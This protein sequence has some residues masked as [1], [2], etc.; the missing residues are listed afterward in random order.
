[1]TG[2]YLKTHDFLKPLA[3]KAEEAEPTLR[4]GPTDRAP[5]VAH[6]LPGGIGTYSISHVAESGSAAEVKHEVVTC[7]AGPGLGRK[8]EPYGAVA[9]TLW[10][11]S[12]A[13][14]KDN[15]NRG[16]LNGQ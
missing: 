10:G 7:A 4:A 5:S 13:A 1:M 11:A 2:F 9:F 3:E 15:G 14:A 6:V 16:K 8:P 12:S